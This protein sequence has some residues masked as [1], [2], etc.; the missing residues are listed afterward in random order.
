MVKNW[1]ASAGGPGYMG[2]IPGLGKSPEKGNGKPLQYSSL[3]NPMDR[4]ACGLQSLGLQMS[5]TQLSSR[6]Q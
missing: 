3:R 2:S 6:P 1:P 5:W 4:G